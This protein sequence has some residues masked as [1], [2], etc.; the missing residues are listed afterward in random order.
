MKLDKI[1]DAPLHSPGLSS[2]RRRLLLAGALATGTGPLLSAPAYA[3]A[4]G[5]WPE[6]PIRYIVP[7]AAGGAT[8]VLGRMLAEG[9]TTALGQ[10]VVVENRPGQGGSL[11]STEVARAKPDGYTIG[12]GTISSHAINATLYSKLPYD[13]KKDFEAV[14]LIAS[15]PNMLV[16]RPE[17]GVK[18]VDEFVAYVKAHPDELSYGSAGNGTSQHISGEMFKIATGTRIQHIPYKGSGQMITDLLG[19]A[20][21][22][23]FENINAA[24]PHVKSGRLVPIAVTSEQRSFML[25]DVP[26]MQEAGVKDYA[27]ASWQAFFAPAGTPAPIVARLNEEANK[28]LRTPAN[29][30]RLQEMGMT[31]GGGSPDDLAALIA[32]DI[33]RLGAIVKATGAVID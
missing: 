16:V 29:A 6:R 28:I 14:M 13:P 11:G 15:L 7:F 1:T 12:G 19:G 26:T 3:Q 22:L 20:I 23:S 5:G 21:Q 10:P 17:L 4:V 2:S 32:K 18:T 30:K 25:P 27:I 8:D 9:L 31:P 24:L 33:P